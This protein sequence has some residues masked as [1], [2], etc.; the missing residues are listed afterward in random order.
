MKKTSQTVIISPTSRIGTI[1]LGKISQQKHHVSVLLE[2]D[3]TV[4]L[5]SIKKLKNEGKQISFFTWMIKAIST[6]IAEQRSVHALSWEKGKLV[7]FDDIDITAMVEKNIKGT[8]VPLPL[9]IK[10]TNIKTVEQIH[11]EIQTAKVRV[12]QDEGDYVLS[13]NSPSR[14][15]MKLFYMLPQFIRLFVL[16]RILQNPFRTKEMMGTTIVTTVGT[17]GRLPGWIIPRSMHNLCFAI[18]SI[19]KKPWVF[20]ERIEIRDILHLTVLFNHDTVDGV[21]AARFIASL[22]DHIEGNTVSP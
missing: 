17:V 2:I 7:I 6:V 10:Q 14:S 20:E 19:V 21:P 1:D 15:M 4:P 12:V 5:E 22:V 9:V 3:V 18:G 13:E 8:R 16:R 11:A